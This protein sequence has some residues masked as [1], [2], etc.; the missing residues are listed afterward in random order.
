M[1]FLKF[2]DADIYYEVTGQGHPFVMQHAGIAHHAMWDP[3]VEHFSRDYRVIT[4]DQRGFGKTET[5]TKNLNRRADLLALFD[6]L[7]VDRGILM[8]C[9]M[10]GAGALDFAL[11]YPDR[12]AALIL[13]A[14]GMSGEPK[15]AEMQ[16]KYDEQDAAFTSGDFEKVIE[17]ELKMWVDGPNRTP[18][19]VPAHVR[20]QV[21]EME[22]DNFKID[23]DGYTSVPLDPP[24]YDR[25]HEVKVPT[26]V[27]YGTGDQPRVVANGQKLAREIPNAQ[28]LILEGIGHLPSMEKPEEV[29]RA[30]ERFLEGDA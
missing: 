28:L 20:A 16:K 25:L 1:P 24:A 5:T 13:V 8:G 22:L 30:I 7:Q 6:Q 10:G 17:L 19:Q 27:I 11:E 29:N 15:D 14:A 26:L 21:R 3:Q 23:T 18:D 2:N 4:F 9:S 12:V